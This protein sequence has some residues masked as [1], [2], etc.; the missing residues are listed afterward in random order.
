MLGVISAGDRLDDKYLVVGRLGSGG[1]GEVFL[2]DD[3]AIPGRQVALKILSGRP[4]GEHRALIH[5]MQ[6]LAQFS[7]P[8]VVT[9]HHHFMH[10]GQLV[11]AM[12]YCAGGS[13][14]DRL[15]SG[16]PA[17]LDEVFRWGTVL[18][19]TLTFVHGKGIVHHDIKPANILFA[20]DGSLK[21]GDFGVANMNTGTRIYL[22][23]EMLLG[24]PVSRTDARVDVYALGI[25]LIEAATGENP[26]E[27]LSPDA[28]L[29][30]RVTHQTVPAGLPRWAQEVLLR[31][32]H[33]T[34]ELRFQNMLEFGEAIRARHVPYVLDAQRIKAH[35]MA[36]RAERLLE[37]KKWKE[38]QRL[39]D[40]ALHLSPACTAALMA[41]GRCQLLI[42][43]TDQAKAFFGRALDV[44]PRMHVQKELGWLHLEEG[45]IPVAISLLCDHIDRNAADFEAYNLLL[46]CFYLSGRFEAGEDLARVMMEQKT[47]SDCFRNNRFVCRMLNDGYTTAA[48]NQIDDSNLVNPFVAYN[49]AVAREVPS[50]WSADGK[51]ALRDKLLFQDYRFGLAKDAHKLNTI[52]VRLPD[53][54]L[55]ETSSSVVTLGSLSANE[56]VLDERS[57]SRRHAVITNL[58]SEVWLHDL[59]SSVGTEMDGKKV[60]GRVFLDGVHRVSIGRATIEVAS[61]SDLLV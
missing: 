30:A 58:P 28:A 14:D 40:Q 1:F 47:P 49:L 52:C 27:H 6:T 21:V 13:W 32:T 25:T 7:H 50:S 24:E 38:A 4:P 3:E 17:T 39:A 34:P 36:E 51:P 10:H 59:G 33:P 2:A 15:A 54:S 48:L 44:S 46:K 55:R 26:F 18:C 42:R 8:G 61:R 56:M 23:P 53:G 9:F 41:A 22:P 11:L 19:D 29:R 35:A 5:E 43:R 37:R 31:A 60:E 16:S 57:V 45:N 20:Q 12:E